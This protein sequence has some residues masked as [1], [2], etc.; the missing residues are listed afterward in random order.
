[1]NV[2]DTYPESVVVPRESV[3]AGSGSPRR[4]AMMT[5]ESR[6]VNI[7]AKTTQAGRHLVL[8]DYRLSSRG[9]RCANS[10]RSTVFAKNANRQGSR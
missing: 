1:M 8:E 5:S 6:P 10:P 3:E 2:K 4:P 9:A 7:T